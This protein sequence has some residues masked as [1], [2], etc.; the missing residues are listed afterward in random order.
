MA[1]VL[2]VIFLFLNT[3]LYAARRALLVAVADYPQGIPSL[4]APVIDA[5]R[6]ADFLHKR[7]GFE[8]ECIA[9]LLNEKVTTAGLRAAIERELVARVEPDDVA[10]FFF[11][12]HGTH[13]PD[14]DGDE[15]DQFDEAMVTIDTDPARP[16]T[17]FTDDVLRYHL[18]RLKTNRA[19]V[20]LDACHAGTGTRA[21]GASRVEGAKYV[22]F[23]F[24]KTASPSRGV[25]KSRAIR[26]AST[27]SQHLVMA[28]CH[29]YEIAR[30]IPKQ[31]G[32][33]T[34]ALL[35]ALN[36]VPPDTAFA[37]IH[38]DVQMAIDRL[39]ARTT[40]PDLPQ[41]PH[42][43]GPIA[44]NIGDFM[45]GASKEGGE[46]PASE[47]PMAD[48]SSALVGNG[49]ITVKLST[50]QSVYI[51][52]QTMTTRV[53]VSED[54][55]LRLYY[56]GADQRTFLIFPNAYQSDH[57]VRAGVPLEV[58]GPNAKFTFRMAPP[59]GREILLAVA[60]KK[61]FDALQNGTKEGAFVEIADASI[62]AMRGQ[63]ADSERSGKGEAILI[64]EVKSKP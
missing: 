32:F 18:S 11:S 59:Y 37:K 30:E 9:M 14:I 62:A 28:A 34:S 2:P 36:S 43:Q 33:F 35:E 63:T 46:K 53:E 41:T 40:R 6:M 55:H 44:R 1:L 48:P 57:F 13:V 51:E 23:G 54:C 15:T 45:E 22:H 27:N 4:T 61:P 5:E 26:P 16:E 58:P 21:F 60:R 52:G 12:G 3:P 29:P 42:F 50:D 20:V 19:I 10:F 17:W 7:M 25:V 49:A 24:D 56:K 8:K 31:G 38:E 39:I 64:Y 47:V